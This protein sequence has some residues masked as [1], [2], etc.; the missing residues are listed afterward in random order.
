MIR[1]K[2][3]EIFRVEDPKKVL[4]A[5]DID[6]TA[7]L[8][9]YSSFEDDRYKEDKQTTAYIYNT[10]FNLEKT[11]YNVRVPSVGEFKITAFLKKQVNAGDFKKRF[12]YQLTL[13]G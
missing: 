8:Y 6:A 11:G 5:V 10:A 1:Y 13:E 7:A 2:N 3:C 4:A 9:V 12:N